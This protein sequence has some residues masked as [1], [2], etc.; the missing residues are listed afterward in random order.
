M[1]KI[2]GTTISI[3]RGDTLN[4]SINLTNQDGSQY[5]KHEGDTIR[6]AMKKNY[7]DDVCILKKDIPVDTMVLRLESEETKSLEMG[8]TYV[9]DIQLTMYDGTV[10]TFIDKGKLKVTEEVD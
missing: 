3:T 7:A 10:N 6:F 1:T 4:V 2:E 8:T 9:Y 5:V